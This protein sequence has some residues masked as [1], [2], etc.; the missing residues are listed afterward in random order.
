VH[1][2]AATEQDGLAG[3]VFS[4]RWSL[5]VPDPSL[6]ETWAPP[7]SDDPSAVRDR[8]RALDVLLDAWRQEQSD[9]AGLITDLKLVAGYRSRALVEYGGRLLDAGQP[10]GAQAAGL[11]ALDAGSGRRIGALNPPGVFVLLAEASLRLGRSREALDM[12]EP[13]L[14]L[15]PEV[16]GIDETLG[17]LVVLDGMARLGDSKEN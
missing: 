16:L 2:Q 9:E 3:V 15:H 10:A 6:P 14:G 12:L 5:Q 4:G 7:M 11:M 8:I 1:A 17:D 13:L